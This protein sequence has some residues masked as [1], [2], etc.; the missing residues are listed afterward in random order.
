LDLSDNG[1]VTVGNFPRLVRVSSLLLSN[2]RVEHVDGINLQRNVANLTTLILSN[3]RITG[4]HEVEN[5]A[6]GCKRLE[7]LCLSGNPVAREYLLHL[8][9][10]D[11]LVSFVLASRC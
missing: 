7:F 11:S 9:G 3:N 6:T 5:I 2:N 10:V 4:L 1:I 8:Y